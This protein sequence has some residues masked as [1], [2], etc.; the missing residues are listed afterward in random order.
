MRD[1]ATSQ[2]SGRG[3]RLPAGATQ[4]QEKRTNS[5]NFVV[6]RLRGNMCRCSACGEFFASVSTFDRH[7]IGRYDGGRRCLLIG[8]MWA[9]G[10][11]QNIEGFW[12]RG[13][14]IVAPELS[15]NAQEQ[16][17]TKPQAELRG[18]A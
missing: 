8:E 15:R 1:F 16:R 17:S 12:I 11:I 7:R 18:A 6:P 5:S 4:D 2:L 14:R 10:W 13:Q 9:K 3:A